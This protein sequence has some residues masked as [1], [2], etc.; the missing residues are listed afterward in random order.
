MVKVTVKVKVKVKAKDQ[1]LK[2]RVTAK[3]GMREAS[4][5]NREFHRSF[6]FWFV[7]LSLYG[8]ENE[9]AQPPPFHEL[10]RSP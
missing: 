5:W 4:Q 1:A 2:M 6:P 3:N 8:E 10:N 7:T 9:T